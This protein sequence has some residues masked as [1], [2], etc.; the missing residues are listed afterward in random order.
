MSSSDHS[1]EPQLPDLS[2]VGQLP[3]AAHKHP[4]YEG[5]GFRPPSGTATPQLVTESTVP[6]VNGLGWPGT[7][8]LRE[9]RLF[10]TR[11]QPMVDSQIH[12]L[13]SYR[14]S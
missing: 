9:D 3:A 10:R 7:L 12:L 14:H 13:P 2:L 11:F 6:D 5:Y 4:L 1:A 8:S